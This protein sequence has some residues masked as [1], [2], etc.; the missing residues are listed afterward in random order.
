MNDILLS[1]QSETQ[2]QTQVD[3]EL[4]KNSS[5]YQAIAQET[6]QTQPQPAETEVEIISTDSRPGVQPEV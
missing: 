1:S 6:L 5:R 4:L 2:L 3:D